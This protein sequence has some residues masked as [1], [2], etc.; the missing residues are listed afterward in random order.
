MSKS[1]NLSI[2]PDG[3]FLLTCPDCGSNKV[4]IKQ[5]PSNEVEKIKCTDCGN[6]VYKYAPKEV[7][8]QITME[9]YLRDKENA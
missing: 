3:K 1:F 5:Y 9:E 7:T 6:A 4:E 8:H 2:A